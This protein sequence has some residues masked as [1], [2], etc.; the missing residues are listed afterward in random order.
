MRIGFITGEYPPM[1]GGV[2]AFTQEMARAMAAQGHEVRV[3]TNM[4]AE[5][6]NTP[7]VP[8]DAVIERWR[9]GALRTVDGWAR[10]HALDAVNIQYQTAAY[11]MS[12]FIHL[13]PRRLR[14]TV[15]VFTTFHDLREPYLFP[16]AGELRTL[17]VLALARDAAGAIVT[18]REDEEILAADPSIANL[19]RIAI[20]SNIAAANKPPDYTRAKWR[21][22][23]GAG[24]GDLLIG[25]FGFLNASKGA[26]VLVGAAK[27][28]QDAGVPARVL[29][30]GGRL[31][32]SDPT[33]AKYSQTIDD[34]I[35]YLGIQNRVHWTG[36]VTDDEVSAYFDACDLCALPYR[37]GV[38]LRRGTF[39]AAIAHGC[40]VITTMPF[41]DI[42]ELRPGENVHLIQRRD[43]D[44]LAEAIIDL[45]DKPA[46]RKQLGE[47]A[48][49]LAALFTW[50]RLAAQTV[51]FF[52]EAIEAERRGG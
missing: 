33:N 30:I 3:L 1:Q 20:G 36:F 17:A 31:G 13:L 9:W 32:A 22:K 42:P 7:G 40:P 35:N 37:D 29:M 51:A 44:A 8:V 24:A 18:N 50:D 48:R 2:G 16:K 34:L 47:G 25:Y 45:A 4:Q 15:P 23:V 5:D 43:A 52:Q 28:A 6:A 46:V 21:K 14:G 39:M 12:P 11:N 49:K 41:I 38:S 10:V 27:K 26:H 19:R